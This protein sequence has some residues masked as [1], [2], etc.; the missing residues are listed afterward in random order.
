MSVPGG[1]KFWVSAD[2]VELDS[3]SRVD[4]VGTRARRKGSVPS[5]VI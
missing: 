1:E 4:F 5:G 2:I 3:E